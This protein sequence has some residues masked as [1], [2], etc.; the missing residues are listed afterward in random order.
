MRGGLVRLGGFEVERRGPSLFITTPAS[1]TEVAAAAFIRGS[2]HLLALG[3]E[4]EG[5]AELEG[6]L[7]F[8]ARGD[9]VVLRLGGHAESLPVAAVER[10]FRDVAAL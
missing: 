9:T 2:N 8:R 5:E 6:G 1:R 10:F 4:L 3:L 7:V